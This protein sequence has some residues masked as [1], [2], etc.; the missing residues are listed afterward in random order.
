MADIKSTITTGVRADGTIIQH[1]LL[2]DTLKQYAGR[3]VDITIEKVKKKRSLAQNRVYWA[4]V[5]DPI[6]VGLQETGN[7]WS[8][9][10]VNEYLKFKFLRCWRTNQATGE[11]FEDIQSTSELSTVQFEDFRLECKEFALDFLGVTLQDPDPDYWYNLNEAKKGIS[12]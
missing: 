2:M 1:K 3:S 4:L 5:V 9:E 7:Y 11:Q 12:I 10:K 8:K 6:R